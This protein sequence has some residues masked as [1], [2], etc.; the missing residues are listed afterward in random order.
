M[1]IAQDMDTFT[2]RDLDLHPD[3]LFRPYTAGPILA[4]STALPT[5]TIMAF[6]DLLAQ[7]E[8]RQAVD[9]NFSIRVTDNRTGRLLEV[10]V[11]E[12]CLHNH[13]MRAV[14][15]SGTTTWA[16]SRSSRRS[17]T[18]ATAPRSTAAAA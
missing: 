17:T 6:R 4:D 7:Y 5:S 12:E 11:W 16:T 1:Q 10:G 14:R 15:A 2:F 3:V 18:T 13:W 8:Q 9:D